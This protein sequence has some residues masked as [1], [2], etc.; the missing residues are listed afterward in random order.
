MARAN[1]RS[2]GNQD[3]TITVTVDEEGNF[4]FEVKGIKGDSCQ[5]LSQWLRDM[6]DVVS[7]DKTDEFYERN[8][9]RTTNTNK[10][11]LTNR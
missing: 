7:E 4:L 2:E 9:T 3:H 11:R 10:R 6:G 5:G 1:L 8:T